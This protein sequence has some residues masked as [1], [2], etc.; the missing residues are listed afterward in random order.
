[1]GGGGEELKVIR[2]PRHAPLPVLIP[3]LGPTNHNHHYRLRDRLQ[4]MAAVCPNR[5]TNPLRRFSFV[6]TAI[7]K[8]PH[9]ASCT[10]LRYTKK[11]WLTN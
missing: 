6:E 4:I 9:A 2:R 11:C 5:L 1:M 3:P 7:K 8:K 10:L